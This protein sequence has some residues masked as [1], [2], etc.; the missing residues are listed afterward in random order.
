MRRG[1]ARG[2]FFS[3]DVEQDCPPYLSSFRGIEEGLPALLGMLETA[4]VAGTFFTT[5]EV[6]RRF[7]ATIRRIV[8]AGHE[9]GCHGDTHR[10]LTTLTPDEAER[11][12]ASAS[13]I[14]RS[15]GPVISFRAPFLRLPVNL[16]EMLARHGYLLDSSQ[17]RYKFGPL[18]RI[19]GDSPLIRVPASVTP[20]VLRLPR[21][22][23]NAWLRALKDPLVLFVHPWE[24]VDLRM[25]K[26][27]FDCRFGTGAPALAALSET[28]AGLRAGGRE[29][30]RMGELASIPPAR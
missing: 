2:A 12:I 8:D 3:V 30:R 21:F 15:F 14:L 7:P 16:V 18:H 5:G 1:Q 13:G 19:G 28:L 9:L 6:A 26:I 4:G 27:R 10:D 29:F 23:R 17:A 22:I 25:E 20:S 11:E 24:F